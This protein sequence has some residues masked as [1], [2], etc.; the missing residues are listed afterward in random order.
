MQVSAAAAEGAEGAEDADAGTGGGDGAGT[1]DT[2]A[3]MD[4]GVDGAAVA[5]AAPGRASAKETGR[6]VRCGL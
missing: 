3:D 1:L 4:N 6:A 2:A 5:A